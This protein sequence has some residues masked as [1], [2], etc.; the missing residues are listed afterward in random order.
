M[1]DAVGRQ[2]LGHIVGGQVEIGQGIHIHQ[3]AG[4]SRGREVACGRQHRV[5]IRNAGGAGVF[6]L[7]GQRAGLKRFFLNINAVF[8]GDQL[9]AL[10]GGDVDKPRLLLVRGDDIAGFGGGNRKDGTGVIP[11]GQRFQ[12][13]LGGQLAL[14][15]RRV[16]GGTLG[17]GRAGH[18]GYIGNVF[19]GQQRAGQQQNAAQQQRRHARF[20]F[21]HRYLPIHTPDGFPPS[22][23]P[24]HIRVRSEFQFHRQRGEE[25]RFQH[26]LDRRAG[27]E[28]LLVGRLE[29]DARGRAVV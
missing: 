25:R 3:L 8:G 6:Q 17:R 27:R 21:A 19:A 5:G 20:R 24:A 15:L 12:P 10:D 1:D 9:V 13:F 18:V 28:R 23:A 16:V 2:R 14:G 7:R 4:R 29:Y 22:G 26:R 11:L